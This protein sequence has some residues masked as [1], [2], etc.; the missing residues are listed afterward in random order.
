MTLG[1]WCGLGRVERSGGCLERV[2]RVLSSSISK[3][4]QPQSTPHTRPL[5]AKQAITRSAD[6]YAHAVLFATLVDLSADSD[7]LGLDGASPH[8]ESYL[9]QEGGLAAM[10]AGG[11]VRRGGLGAGRWLGGC[12]GSTLRHE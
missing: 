2:G 5:P 1:G 6:A 8:L 12:L 11:Q 7:L 3:Q 10:S 9:R 4:Q